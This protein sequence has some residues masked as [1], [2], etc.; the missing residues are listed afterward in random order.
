MVPPA[1][2]SQLAL[3]IA[4][5][6]LDQVELGRIGWQEE[7]LE[8]I[9][10]MLPVRTH[11]MAFVVAGVVEHE[12]GRFGRRQG[13][14]EVVQEGYECGLLFARARLPEDLPTHIVDRAKDGELVVVAGRGHLQRLPFAPPDLCQVGVGMDF[15]LVH[16]DQMESVS[17][18][19]LGLSSCFF[20]SQ[21]KT[22]LAAATAARSC[23]WV[24]S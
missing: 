7:G 3:Q 8:P 22:C 12:H 21:S 24:R 10:Q 19:S 1:M 14:G 13:L 18:G 6:A 15:A 11:R 17:S 2:A 20:W 9:R 16:V 5:E 23:R 4:P